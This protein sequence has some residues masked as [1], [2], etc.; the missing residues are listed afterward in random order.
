MQE[1]GTHWA[2]EEIHHPRHLK[3]FKKEKR[4]KEKV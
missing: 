2:S 3:S 1:G 4:T